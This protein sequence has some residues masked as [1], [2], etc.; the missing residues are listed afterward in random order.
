MV[1]LNRKSDYL[2]FRK[3]DVYAKA[4]ALSLRIHAL[5]LAFPKH[6]QYSLADQFRRCS[7][8]VCANLAEGF[9]KQSF[10][11][12]EFRRFISM[13]I[14]STTESRVWN[15]YARDLGYVDLPT[16]E[17]IENELISIDKML[18]SLHQKSH[19]PT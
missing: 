12:P 8:S 15:D 9:G 14:G 3:L 17:A 1:G 13:S 5:S 10:S 11:K 16:Y 6:E 19:P 4:Y 18:R 2:S 7:R